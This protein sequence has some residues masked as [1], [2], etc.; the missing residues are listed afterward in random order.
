MHF[1]DSQ[2]LN[3][4]KNIGVAIALQNLHLLEPNPLLPMQRHL[5]LFYSFSNTVSTAQSKKHLIYTLIYPLNVLMK[6]NKG[7]K[8]QNSIRLTVSSI[9]A[10]KDTL[11]S[12]I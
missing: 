1:I 12:H 10:P 9:F 5:G 3:Y 8:D 4:L 2:L 7:K 6:R 11:D